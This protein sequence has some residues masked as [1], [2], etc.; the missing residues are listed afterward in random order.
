MVPYYSDIV[1][2]LHAPYT[3]Y[4]YR[5]SPVH[6]N[7]INNFPY[8]YGFKPR[9]AYMF[10]QMETEIRKRYFEKSMLV[11]K[12][13][14]IIMQHCVNFNLIKTRSYNLLKQIAINM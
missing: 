7:Y 3:D 12:I 6:C 2:S 4:K 1:S 10:S 13:T 9:S 5:R 11:K 14:N 8:A